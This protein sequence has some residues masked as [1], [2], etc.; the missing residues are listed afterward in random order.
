MKIVTLCYC[1]D[2]GKILLGFKKTGFGAGKYNG[3]GGKVEAGETIT[4]ATLREL[5][6]ESG[7]IGMPEHLEKVAEIEFSFEGNLTF[8]CHVHVLRKW[9]G[10]LR[11]SNEMTCHWFALEELPYDKMWVADRTWLPKVLEGK[12]LKVFVNFNKE[13][14]KVL[15]IN[16]TETVFH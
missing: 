2:R 7:V 8:Q 6:E 13:G 15:E 16:L 3:F 12:K 4:Q 5:Q 14:N 9:T 1:F 11:E 10:E